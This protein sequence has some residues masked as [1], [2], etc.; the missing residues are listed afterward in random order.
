MQSITTCFKCEKLK[1]SRSCIVWG[2]GDRN[3]EFMFIGMAPGRNGADRTGI[4]F[5][6]DPSGILF[7]ESLIN[8][9]L[10]LEENPRNER[11][12]LKDVY[13]TNLVKCNPKDANGR[14][15]TPSP[16][17]VQN[18]SL[19]LEQ[20][21]HDIEPK[22]VILLGKVVAEYVLKEKIKKFISVHQ[23]PRH[24]EDRI[25]IPFIHPSYVIRGAYDRQQYI[26][27]I[28]ALKTYL[29][30]SSLIMDE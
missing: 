22:I 8:A 2:Y 1:K 28:A 26:K 24:I 3:A 4:P 10:S 17:E 9:K 13:I 27:E 11:P 21:L 30:S 12:R 20:E 19:Y 7:Q 5:T 18:C 6:R 29:V 25:Y 15:R 23:K 16:E 14:N